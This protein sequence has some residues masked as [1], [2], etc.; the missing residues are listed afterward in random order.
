MHCFKA[1]AVVK[2]LPW[3]PRTYQ[4]LCNITSVEYTSFSYEQVVPTHQV[5]WFSYSDIATSH[6]FF[7]IILREE[8][9]KYYKLSDE[10]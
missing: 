5:E 6:I 4:G 3:I 2:N 1:R 10:N 8:N 7:F 9:R